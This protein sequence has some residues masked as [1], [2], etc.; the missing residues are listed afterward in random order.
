MALWKRR[1]NSTYHEQMPQIHQWRTA[2]PPLSWSQIADKLQCKNKQTIHRA[3]QYWLSCQDGRYQA[4]PPVE[5]PRQ[6]VDAKQQRRIISADTSGGQLWLAIG[7][8]HRPFHNQ[9]LWA[10]I[11]RLCDWLG[12]R[13]HG[14]II[15]G[16]YLDMASLSGHD[17]G[18]L[19][20]VDN[21]DI[22]FE[23]AD[24]LKGIRELTEATPNAIHHYIYGNHED[25]WSRD[26]RSVEG[27]KRAIAEPA[28]ALYLDE[29]GWQVHRNWAEDYV[30]L[31][32]HL[33]VMHGI[34]TCENAAK[35]H[36]ASIG[37]SAVFFHTHRIH[38]WR[39]GNRVAYNCG[40]LGDI[41][42]VG[43]RYVGRLTRGKWANGFALIDIDDDG[44]FFVEPVSCY[45][46]KFFAMGRLF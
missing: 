14:V 5:S 13:L 3:Y 34:F 31:G 1:P 41:P 46:D 2:Q 39:E 4:T 45:N 17:I 18:K 26:R 27:R 42:S 36:L 11:L 21:L 37:G 44:D 25:R 9:A 22:H 30:T 16:D 24:G 38:S 40:M 28:E 43:F 15:A 29:Y 7:C 35:K 8:V 23:Y 12:P 32:K 6:A 33:D 20:V 19:P 10:K